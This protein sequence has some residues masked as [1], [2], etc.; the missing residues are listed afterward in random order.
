[1][2][3]T[4]RKVGMLVAAATT[5]S[6]ATEASAYFVRPVAQYGQGEMMDG[7]TVNG[8]T[9]KTVE[10]HDGF[11]SLEAS[12]DL[13]DGTIKTFASSSGPQSSFLISTG[14]YGDTIRYTGSETESVSFYVDFDGI[15]SSNQY[16]L[17]DDIPFNQ[18][19]IGVDA[20]FAVFEA[21]TGATINCWTIVC[22]NLE[23]VALY[24]DRYF[25][26][27]DV[28]LDDYQGFNFSLGSDLFLKP[29]AKYEVYVA[30]NLLLQPGIYGG[31]IEMD[32]RNT[33]RLSIYAPNGDFTS[34]SGALL[35][36][37]KTPSVPGGVPEPAT[38]A[39]M[40]LG[41]GTVG[42]AARRR[43]PNIV[44]A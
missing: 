39:M 44:S 20:Y 30:F 35:G 24:N 18:R 28:G 43:R 1:M 15:I 14:I 13:A 8:A 2:K 11:T 9:K 12:V 40:L 25:T 29:N 38:W 41:F 42:Y 26:S 17:G 37:E 7:L 33:S 32:S 23:G 27:F 16:D 22:Q 10:F 31:Y 3:M 5:I 36:F 6:M 4:A 19:Y 34:E 21:G